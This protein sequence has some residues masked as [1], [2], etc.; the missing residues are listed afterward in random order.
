MKP[1]DG[2]KVVDL[3]RILA[4][5]YCSMILAD[6]GAEVVKIENPDGG[7]DT[8]AWGPPFLEG[9]ST[10]FLS[11]NRN[12]KSLTL[13]LKDP[14]GKDVLRRLIAQ[15]DVLLENFRP[16][17]LER[18]GF[19]YEAVKVL[20]SRMVYCSVSGFGQT[21]PDAQ[22]PG[23]DLIAQGESGLM[24]ITGYAEGPPL[25][26]GTSIAD[27][28]AGTLAAQGILLALFAR[29]RTGRGQLV[30]VALLDG[31]LSVLTYQAGSYF[32][33]GNSPGRR[34]NQ[35]PSIT[36]YEAYEAKDGH[37]NIGVANNSLY[38]KFCKVLGRE[39][40][41]ADPRFR[42]DADRV[43]NRAALQAILAPIIKTR[44]VRE[45]LAAFDAA[46][47][48]AGAI[49]S[50]GEALSA[51][52]ALAREMVTEVVHPKIG[53][54][55][56]TGIPVKLSDTPGAVETPPPLLG[57][58]TDEVLREWVGLRPQDIAGLRSGRVI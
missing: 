34:G 8:R 56:V 39:D 27:I 6:M 14:R 26:V 57:Q 13:N 49:R 15:G 41:I 35:H 45:W 16:G 55:K 31:M 18:L 19:G 4:G 22:R 46:G 32:A 21:G 12:K 38:D 30:D 3:S 25:K 42:G 40:L 36:P 23:Y 5:P 24:S 58:H 48:P 28:F 50:V 29:E 47:I 10:Y 43:T 51:A 17:A 54:M 1:L 11:I 7:D 9:E 53:P 20:N 52:Q 37:L 44:T 2:I 33:T